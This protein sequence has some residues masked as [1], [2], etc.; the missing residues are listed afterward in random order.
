MFSPERPLLIQGQALMLK[1][2]LRKGLRGG[3]EEEKK[4]KRECGRGVGR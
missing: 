4:R 1:G 3:V 2:N